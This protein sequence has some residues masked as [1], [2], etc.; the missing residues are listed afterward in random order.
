MRAPNTP[1][2]TRTPSRLERGTEVLVQRL[3]DLGRRGAGEAR[4]IPLARVRDQRELAHDERLAADVEER[5]VEAAVLVLED[6]Q[7]RDLSGEAFGRRQVI[8]LRD[9][10]QDRQPTPDRAENRA[11]DGD[12]RLGT[13]CNTARTTEFSPALREFARRPINER[14]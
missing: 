11:V 10:Q 6:P 3:G 8:A 1:R 9:P 14:K 13:R 5:A 12:R 2:A 7:A 4:A